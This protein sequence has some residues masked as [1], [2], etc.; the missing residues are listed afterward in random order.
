MS[1]LCPT[2][3]LQLVQASMASIGA[4]CPVAFQKILGGFLPYNLLGNW[5]LAPDSRL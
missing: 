2:S 5:R 1:R 4:A 3:T